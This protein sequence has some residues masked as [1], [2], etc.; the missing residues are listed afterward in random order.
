MQ[1]IEKAAKLLNK[2]MITLDKTINVLIWEL[3]EIAN[4][5]HLVACV[6]N[7]P[8]RESC[9]D[10]KI[11]L[12]WNYVVDM[13]NGHLTSPDESCK[14]YSEIGQIPNIKNK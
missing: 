3:K 2:E 7:S 13:I 4:T 11:M 8:R 12:S 1:D 6:K 5:L 10:R 9:L 14:Y